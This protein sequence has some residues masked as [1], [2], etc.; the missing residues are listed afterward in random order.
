VSLLF[1]PINEENRTQLEMRIGEFLL[2]KKKKASNANSS[3]RGANS[4]GSQGPK[5]AEAKLLDQLHLAELKAFL[6]S[7]KGKSVLIKHFRE[8]S[9]K[10]VLEAR[11]KMRALAGR[12]IF[13][14]L[15]MQQPFLL[16]ISGKMKIFMIFI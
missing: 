12:S 8:A 9:D 11:T 1:G 14:E 5:E 2:R 13:P 3:S 7:K 15:E 10:K 16:R 4:G 6:L